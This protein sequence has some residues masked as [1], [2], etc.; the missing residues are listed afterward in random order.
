MT[1]V[2]QTPPAQSGAAAEDG[3]AID[4][5]GGVE[6]VMGD[7]GIFARI[8]ERFRSD[9]RRAA[10]AIRAALAAGD[11]PLAQRLT[12]TLKGASGMIEAR[13]LQRQALALEQALGGQPAD[14]E[15]QLAR[16]DAELDRVLREL[17]AMVGAQAAQVARADK[18]QAASLDAAVAVERLAALLDS[19]DGAALELVEEAHAELAAA[20]GEA[21]WREVA[22][23][24]DDFDFERA[25]A[26]LRGPSGG[27]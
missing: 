3:A 8:L 15:P 18:P 2:P 27:P 16:L 6:R 20:L 26:L 5:A 7:H 10:V 9:Y 17:D 13:P 22:A 12:H 1:N 14:W 25:L 4:L 19:G 21:R 24:V 23:A 11:T